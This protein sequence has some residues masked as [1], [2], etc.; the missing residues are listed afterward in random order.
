M[1][2]E[3]NLELTKWETTQKRHQQLSDALA[4]SFDSSKP[5]LAN[6]MHDKSEDGFPVA[7]LQKRSD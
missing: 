2:D 1:V 5:S 6:I 3:Q 4:A 7:P